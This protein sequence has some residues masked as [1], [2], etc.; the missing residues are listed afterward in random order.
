[1]KDLQLKI[2]EVLSSQ[3]QLVLATQDKDY[4][5]M[6]LMAYAYDDSLQNI[7]LASRSKTRKIQNMLNQA[8]VS[9]LWDNRTGKLS[10]HIDGFS[11]L[12]ICESSILNS[13]LN[14]E[15]VSKVDRVRQ[16]LLHRN[17]TLEPLLGEQD[18]LLIELR[19]TQYDLTLGYQQTESWSLV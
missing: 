10:D 11:L 15:M 2:H 18:C 3:I 4:P 12:A 13:D 1:M 14:S 8:R 5:M 7:Y 19:V 6:H 16:R 17:P 9:L